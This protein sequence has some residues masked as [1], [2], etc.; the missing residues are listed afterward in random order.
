MVIFVSKESIDS[1][2]YHVKMQIRSE[3]FML[4]K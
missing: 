4:K 2:M 3:K 1:Y